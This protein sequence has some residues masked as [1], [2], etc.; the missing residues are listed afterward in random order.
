MCISGKIALK[1]EARGMLL[2]KDSDARTNDNKLL[3]KKNNRQ[4]T[5]RPLSM[6]PKKA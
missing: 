4:G 1:T 5:W 6:R 3:I 2:L